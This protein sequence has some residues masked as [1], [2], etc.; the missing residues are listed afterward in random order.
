MESAL[1]DRGIVAAACRKCAGKRKSFQ[2]NWR[3]LLPGKLYNPGKNPDRT[4]G[5]RFPR[6]A[7][8]GADRPESNQ[9]RNRTN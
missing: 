7:R 3:L 1:L 9:S 5:G 4:G 8:I 2:H 6:I